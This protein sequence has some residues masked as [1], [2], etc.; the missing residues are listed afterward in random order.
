MKVI[1]VT[2]DITDLKYDKY[3]KYEVEVPK[4]NL[5]IEL[6]N[7]GWKHYEHRFKFP[8]NYGASVVKHIGSYGATKDLFELAVLKFEENGQSYL[9]Y[10]TPITDDVLGWLT[11]KDVLNYLKKIKHL[12]RKR[13]GNTRVK[14]RKYHIDRT[15]A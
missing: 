6:D 1:D 7:M 10:D 9:C 5:L 2:K 15:V 11:N 12:R 3:K 13:N 4:H 8:N 14:H